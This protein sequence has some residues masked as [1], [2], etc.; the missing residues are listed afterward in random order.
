MRIPD[1]SDGVI[2]FKLFQGFYKI[3]QK[4]GKRTGQG[5]LAGNQDEIISRLGV[6]RDD[7][8][9]HG[10]ET[11]ARTNL[12]C[13][14]AIRRKSDRR[15]RRSITRGMGFRQIGAC[16][17]WRDVLPTPCDHPRSPCG[18]GNRGG[19]YER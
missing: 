8:S 18:S 12:Q 6:I 7:F 5:S 19:A 3:F 9:N 16:G 10:T 11:T 17:P 1:V 15:L 4:L 2:G 14:A 13:E